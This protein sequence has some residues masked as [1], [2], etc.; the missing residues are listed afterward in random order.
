MCLCRAFASFSCYIWKKC[1]QDT[2]LLAACVQHDTTTIRIV[3]IINNNQIGE[4]RFY[5]SYVQLA[6]ATVP[7]YTSLHDSGAFIV[8]YSV[9]QHTYMCSA[10]SE[11]QQVHAA[12]L[13]RPT[14]THAHQRAHNTPQGPERANIIVHFFLT[15]THHSGLNQIIHFLEKAL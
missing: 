5:R 6:I 14:T 15:D 1:Q 7:T 12:C 4:R 3:V 8:E 2:G 10:D 13:C 11:Q 9:S